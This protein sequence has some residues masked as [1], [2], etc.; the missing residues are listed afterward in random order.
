MSIEALNWAFNV[1]VPS[2]GA[3]LVLLTLANYANEIGEAFPSQKALALKTCLSERAIR[4]NLVRL[5]EMK[6]ISRVPRTR[7]DGSYTTDLFSLNVG[8]EPVVEKAGIEPEIQSETQRQNLPTAEIAD[9]KIL[10]TQRQILPVPAAESAGLEPSLNTTIT[11]SNQ[12][13]QGQAREALVAHGV[14]D[15]LALRW[16]AIR[17]EKSKSPELKK[18]LP[19]IDA[20]AVEKL[21]A[22]AWLVNLRLDQAIAACVSLGWAWFAA[23]WYAELP[24]EKRPVVAHSPPKASTG[25][26]WRSTPAGVLNRG[27]E[28]SIAPGVGESEQAYRERVSKADWDERRKKAAETLGRFKAGAS[29]SE[30]IAA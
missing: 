5:E 17:D 18:P 21:Q 3:K 8:G 13:A 11:K 25:T 12:F 27:K 29:A 15:D 19:A 28:L 1:Q 23:K 26:D 2:A 24:P 10:Q 30:P 6:L 20:A 14:P 7:S 22:E 16:I 9:G 4:D